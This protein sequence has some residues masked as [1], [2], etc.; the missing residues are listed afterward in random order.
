[1]LITKLQAI[2]F[3]FMGLWPLLHYRSFELVTGRKTDVWLVKT[4][5]GLFVVI[6]VQLWIAEPLDVLVLAIGS[7]LAV[8]MA[9]I[10]YSLI[11]NRIRFIYAAD[12]VVQF[13][14]VAAWLLLVIF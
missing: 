13:T 14:F 11:E 1:M 12:A 4:I 7:A 2:Y 9:D 10:Y 8:G 5:A 3:I 6:G